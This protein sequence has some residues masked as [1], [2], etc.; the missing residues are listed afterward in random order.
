MKLSQKV[1]AYQNAHAATQGIEFGQRNLILATLAK[2][3]GLK[4]WIGEKT[5]DLAHPNRKQYLV[6]LPQ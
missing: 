5:F 4:H 2:D 3:L 6:S 1:T